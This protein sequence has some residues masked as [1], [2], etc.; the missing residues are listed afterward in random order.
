MTTLKKKI[1][2]FVYWIKMNR[3]RYRLD[4]IWEK[5]TQKLQGHYNYY[6]VIWNRRKLLHF[7][8]AVVSNLYRWL[9]R[10]SQKTSY[11]WEGFKMRLSS[12]PLAMPTEG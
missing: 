1:Q 12:K 4:V 9:N 3:S 5:T 7:Y 10:R 8:N 11:T 6:G 2:D